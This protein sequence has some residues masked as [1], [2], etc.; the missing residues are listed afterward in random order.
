M[1]RAAPQFAKLTRLR[2]HKAV[3]RVHITGVAGRL[4]G[5]SDSLAVRQFA[6]ADA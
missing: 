1:T 6:V 5:G 2:L 4:R 3:A